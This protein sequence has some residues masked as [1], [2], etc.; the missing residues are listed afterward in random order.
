[1]ERSY[2]LAR[3]SVLENYYTIMPGKG[4]KAVIFISQVFSSGYTNIQYQRQY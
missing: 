1:M 4:E 2:S 3:D